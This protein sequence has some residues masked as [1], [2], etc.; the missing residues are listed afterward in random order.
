MDK[1][2]GPADTTLQAIRHHLK[3]I[4]KGQR[5]LIVLD[6]LW[7]ENPEGLEKLRT[8]LQ[9]GKSGSKI[10]ATTR[11]E[12]VAKLMNESSAIELGALPDN[13]CWK[14]FR[15]KAFPHVN[16]DADKES[17]GR[18]IAQKCRGMPLAAISQ[19]YLCQT[20]DEWEAIRDSNIWAEDGNDGRLFKDT[21]VLP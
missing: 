16:V 13:H 10:I 11:N 1:S 3:T 7:E 9:G 8:L 19:G 18:Q 15:N 12:K 17:I 20:T 5:F 2:S 21:K 4:I 6:D 14:L